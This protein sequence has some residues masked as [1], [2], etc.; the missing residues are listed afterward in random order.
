MRNAVEMRASDIYNGFLNLAAASEC[1]NARYLKATHGT[2][3]HRN[4]GGYERA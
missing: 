4:P 1:L 3:H 2:V